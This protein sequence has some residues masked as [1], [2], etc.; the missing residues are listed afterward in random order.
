MTLY[1]AGSK[2]I[3][4]AVSKE[5]DTRN[6]TYL[7]IRRGAYVRCPQLG[8]KAVLL[9][10]ES[11]WQDNTRNLFTIM[12]SL[13]R[14]MNREPLTDLKVGVRLPKIIWMTRAIG[15]GVLGRFL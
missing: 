5:A 1:R 13:H 4:E 15:Q 9:A 2:P 14:Q 11:G 8:H 6:M 12:S 7:D 10:V 3:N